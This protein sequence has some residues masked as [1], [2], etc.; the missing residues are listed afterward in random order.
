MDFGPVTHMLVK[1]VLRVFAVVFDHK[2]ITADLGDNR[3]R[4]NGKNLGVAM[5]D[6]HLRDAIDID[7]NRIN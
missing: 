1:A 6:G 2:T 7:G 3:G 4:G 5:D